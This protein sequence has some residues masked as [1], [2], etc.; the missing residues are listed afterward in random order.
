M[1][2]DVLEQIVDDYLKLRG[3]FTIHNVK[4]KPSPEHEAYNRSKDS[5]FSDIDVIGVNPRLRGISRVWA[6]SCKAWQSGFD[7][8]HI[9]NQ[10]N[11]KAKQGK[12]EAWKYYRELWEPRWSEAFRQEVITRT[13][14]KRFRYSIAVTHLKGDG[15]AWAR[16]PRI[17][18][19]LAGSS[20]SF[21]TLE[22]MWMEYLG[23]IGT[24]PQPSA[25]GRLAQVLKAAK[26]L[27][28][29]DLDASWTAGRI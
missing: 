12:R 18:S 28:R 11:G 2:E 27:D 17:R 14:A 1:K 29:S 8:N 24:A 26:L 16:D 15:A 25:I 7:A 3:Y 13:G 19:N 9:L 6:V 21:L 20:F 23:A 5:V 22:E 4:F 10:L